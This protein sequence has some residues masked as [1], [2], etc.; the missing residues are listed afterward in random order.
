MRVLVTGI[1]SAFGRMVAR[2]LV[3]GEHEVLGVDRRAWP[4]A[5]RGVTMFRGD[6]RKRQVEEVFRVHRPEAVIHMAT[7]THF[8]ASREDRYRINLYG[9]QKV[10]EHCDRYGVSRAVFVGRHTVYGA[11]G[12][13]PLYHTE[14]DP[15]LAAA[16]FPELADLVAADL[17]AGSALWRWPEL[18]T[19]VLRLVYTL[20]PS[21]RGTLA[22]FL[23]ADRVPGIIGFDPLFH[24]MHELDAVRAIVLALETG[25]H[26]VFNVTGPQPIS[27]SLLCKITGR[28]RVSVPEFLFPS[29]V[30]RFG[31]SNLPEGAVSHIKHPVVL[32][33][34]LFRD[35][36]G[37]GHEFDEAQIMDSF[38]LGEE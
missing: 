5:P 22:S 29:V 14:S 28:N 36:T 13:A 35:T 10:F 9:T 34:Q 6:V 1:S 25:A 18:K 11:A 15:P 19:S 23:W 33:G 2:A 4:D 24:F 16:T 3:E 8:S 17:F 38:R 7:V 32:D 37:F 21:R 12:D 26:G 31:F 20:G 27:L 30:G